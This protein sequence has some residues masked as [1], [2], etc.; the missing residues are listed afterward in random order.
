MSYIEIDGKKVYVR[1]IVRHTTSRTYLAID[2]DT[3]Q[4]Y[5]IAF[6]M[7]KWE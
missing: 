7:L 5:Q 3:K 4:Q 2:D 6:D 1:I